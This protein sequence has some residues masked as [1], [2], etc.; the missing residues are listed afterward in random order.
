M[1]PQIAAII[2]LLSGDK[3]NSINATVNTAVPWT[4]NL[5]NW[6]Q[7]SGSEIEMFSLSP[8]KNA[9]VAKP[10]NH[11]DIQ[12][13]KWWKQK[14]KDKIENKLGDSLTRMKVV[15]SLKDKRYRLDASL[16]R[17]ERAN[18]IKTDD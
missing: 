9:T 1:Y 7:R 8:A 17:S 18:L 13:A 15:P 11:R 12:F 2:Y 14:I 3:S 10:Q 6:T 16:S 4:K 5:A